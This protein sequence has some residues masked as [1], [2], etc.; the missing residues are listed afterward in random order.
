MFFYSAKRVIYKVKLEAMCGIAG[1]FIHSPRLTTEEKVVAQLGAMKKA[2]HSRGPDGA[3]TYVHDRVGLVHTRLSIIDL[4]GGRQPITDSFGVTI[5]FNGE[6]YNY[7]EKRAELVS[8]YPFTTHSDTEVILALYHKYG[9]D[10]IHHLRGMYAV[11]LY[12]PRYDRFILTRDPFGIKPLYIVE[13]AETLGFA[14]EIKAL[15]ASG[16]AHFSPDVTELRRILTKHFTRGTTTV[17]PDVKRLSPGEMRVYEKGVLV[18][19]VRRSFLSSDAPAVMTE[20]EA[21]E[22]LENILSS[23][24]HVHCRSDVGYGIFLSGGVDSVSVLSLLSAQ[25]NGGRPVHSYTARFDVSGGSEESAKAAALAKLYQTQH[26]DVVFGADDFKQILPKLA[27]YM[28]DPVADYAVL[29]T[30]KLAE[31]ARQFDKVV[32]SGEGGDELFAGYGRYYS[33]W[34]KTLFGRKASPASCEISAQWTSLQ[35]KQ[36]ADIADYL[37]NDLL[38]KLDTCLMAHGLEGRTPFLDEEVARFAFSLPDHLK[39]QG[40]CGK[41][42]LKRWL[43]QR[44]AL[45][46]PFAKKSGFTVP[47]GVWI[48]DDHQ[49]LSAFLSGQAIVKD[50]LSQEERLSLPQKLARP[51]TAKD[52]W[53]ILYLA[54]WAAARKI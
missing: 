38:I 35:R 2:L 22:R 4:E 14:S 24:V 8:E 44:C 28:D 40:R 46:Q 18:S 43:D 42:L 53:Q 32:L 27:A 51:E 47:V 33:R 16:L 21:M 10:F 5:V 29:P 11:A 34:W 9:L 15:H 19:S 36:A 25:D 6:I 20:N 50:L 17:F 52:C 3:G 37:P 7:I 23:S 26:H 49:A 31:T 45:A 48:A 30:W 54:H 39:Q 41:Y 13:T 12:D 1:L